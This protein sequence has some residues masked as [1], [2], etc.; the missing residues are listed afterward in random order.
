[1]QISITQVFN[2]LNCNISIKMTI[3]IF[4]KKHEVVQLVVIN[5][6]KH[7]TCY[8]PNASTSTPCKYMSSK[9]FKLFILR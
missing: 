4:L 9:G 6:M 3:K 1:M 7:E 5:F 8:R 2:T